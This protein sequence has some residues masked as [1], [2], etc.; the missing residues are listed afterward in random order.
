MK[1]NWMQKIIKQANECHRKTIAN[2]ESYLIIPKAKEAELLA[3][4]YSMYSV[5]EGNGIPK[6]WQN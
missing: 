6:R 2:K 3:F 4:V 5:G 1:E